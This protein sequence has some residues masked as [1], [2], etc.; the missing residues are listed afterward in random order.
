MKKTSRFLM[1]SS[2]TCSLVIVACNT[3]PVVTK[4]KVVPS[5]EIPLK[6][7]FPV[8]PDMNPCENFYAYTCSK[9]DESFKLREDRSI[10]TFSFS[11]SAER[12]LESKKK[13]LKELLTDKNLTRRG[14]VLRT[15]YSACMNEEAQKKE[16]KL[17]VTNGLNELNAIKTNEEFQKYLSEKIISKDFTFINID[18]IANQ[19]DPQWD[20]IYALADLQS[21][22]ERSYYDKPEVTKDLESLMVDFFKIVDPTNAEVR[23]RAVLNF[24]KD[25]TKT[26]PLPSEFRE[27]ISKKTEINRTDL[28]KKYP[29]F[30]LDS[31]LQFVPNRTKIRNLTPDNFAF[32]NRALTERPL[33]ELKDV[34]AFHSLSD[35]MDDAYPDFFN[36]RFEFTRKHLGG[37]NVRPDRQ[38]RCTKLVMSRFGREMDAELLPKMF[39]NFPQQK[40]IQ[41]A[42]K[43][44]ASILKG[45]DKNQWLSL[46]AK[47]KALSKIKLARLQLV[48]PNRDEDWDFNPSGKYSESTP[49]ENIRG[50]QLKLSKRM[51]QRLHQPRNRNLWGM[52]PLT[53][54]AYY[55]PSDNKFVL[56]IGILQY[57]FYDPSLPEQT[58]MAAVG[59]VIGHELGHAIDDKGSR[60]DET[61][62]LK[63][64]MSDVDVKTFH[65]RGARLAEQ[66]KKVKHDGELT[67]GENVADLVGLTFAFDAAFP[68]GQGDVAAKK[69]F[70]TQ[71]GRLWCTVTRPKYMEMLL[72]T[73][74]HARGEARVNEQVK[75]QPS[76][77]EAYSCPEGSPMTLKSDEVVRI[78]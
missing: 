35:E 18:N 1:F 75:H 57:P 31:A 69:D 45:I 15:I 73:D 8:N 17:L 5:S 9:V 77:K 78:W 41:L 49:I 30:R 68:N 70:F 21:L 6:R 48:K 29:N 42:E 36:K 74:S 11:D 60:Y 46:P 39:P 44:R 25:F 10:H 55:S 61:G 14:K 50:L 26:Y 63:S 33:Q 51:Y 40:V 43:I 32:L 2:L 16:E 56:P 37:P 22:P 38:E 19:D 27:L 34:Y 53:I 59:M 12:I 20:D 62:R 4:T 28:L 65:E 13:Y 72:K 7:E 58:N 47:A 66:F 71:Y 23:A 24:E 54:N 76:F 64:W 67:L 52:S 3:S